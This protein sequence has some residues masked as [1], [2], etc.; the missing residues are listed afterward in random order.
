MLELDGR[1]SPVQI[2]ANII[3]ILGKT[4]V[5]ICETETSSNL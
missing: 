5:I 1:V 4:S 3:L 2:S